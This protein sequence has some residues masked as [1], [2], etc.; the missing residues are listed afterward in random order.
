M[1]EETRVLSL[2]LFEVKCCVLPCA[3]SDV[4]R[5][6][7]MGPHAADVRAAHH[8]GPPHSSSGMF[9]ML[10]FSLLKVFFTWGLYDCQEGK[11]HKEAAR[12][13]ERCSAFSVSG[14][15]VS[16]SCSSPRS[17][18]QRPHPATSASHRVA[19]QATVSP[20]LHDLTTSGLNVTYL[21]S[22]PSVPGLGAAGYLLEMH[23][24][25]PH[26]GPA[27]PEILEMR[28]SRLCFITLSR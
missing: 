22:S 11:P 5:C 28:P 19:R 9:Q 7:S 8:A 20:S 23:I 14:A 10:G 2:E 12:D 25:G 27:E 21:S 13:L 18:L 4:P 26:L 15:K 6:L 16:C 17:S 24:F 1:T 3:G